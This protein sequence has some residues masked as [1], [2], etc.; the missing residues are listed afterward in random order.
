[1]H[2]GL[3]SKEGTCQDVPSYRDYFIYLT[4]CELVHRFIQINQPPVFEEDGSTARTATLCP[5]AVSCLPRASMNVD[6][7]APG[8]PDSPGGFQI[9]S[10]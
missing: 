5:R 2:A 4:Y 3:I 6:F 10:P 7:P 1:M 8:G 9:Q